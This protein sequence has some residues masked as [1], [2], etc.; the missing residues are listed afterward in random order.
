MTAPESTVTEGFALLLGPFG[1]GEY[2]PRATGGSV[3]LGGLPRDPVEAVAVT[4]YGSAAPDAKHGYDVLSVLYR[5]R[6]APND[7]AGPERRAQRLYD[8]LHGLPRRTALPGTGAWLQRCHAT[9]SGPVHARRDTQGRHEL[10]V[11][12]TAEIRR[13]TENRR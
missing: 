11:M 2:R 3:F 8:A 12:F 1:L 13:P 10:T 9:T 5:V 6:G 4:L 7:P